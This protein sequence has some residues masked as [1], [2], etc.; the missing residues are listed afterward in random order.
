MLIFAYSLWNTHSYRLFH[1]GGV[2]PWRITSVFM[3]LGCKILTILTILILI[4]TEGA[5]HVFAAWTESVSDKHTKLMAPFITVVYN[6]VLGLCKL[7]EF[8]G[9]NNKTGKR[10]ELAMKNRRNLGKNGNVGRYDFISI[11]GIL[12]VDY[13]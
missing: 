7:W 11:V 12:V 13:Y 9:R 10:R 1:N 8:H 3:P 2:L 6:K 5:M 4:L